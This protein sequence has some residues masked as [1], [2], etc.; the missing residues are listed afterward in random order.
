M[1]VKNY[2][3][4]FVVFAGFNVKDFAS[5]SYIER[6]RLLQDR[7]VGKKRVF[8]VR[9]RRG[10]PSKRMLISLVGAEELPEDFGS[11]EERRSQSISTSSVTVSFSYD[12]LHMHTCK[13]KQSFIFNNRF[14]Q[15]QFMILVGVMS[16]LIGSSRW[17]LGAFAAPDFVNQNIVLQN[18]TS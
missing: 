8:R 5:K 15:W 14:C 6:I 13:Q 12:A 10:D 1:V 9:V 17:A 3:K 11:P 18:C 2:P 7:F 16:N 4:K